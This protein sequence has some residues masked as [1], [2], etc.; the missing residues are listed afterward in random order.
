MKRKDKMKKN[1]MLS[2]G[3]MLVALFFV[4]VGISSRQMKV[5]LGLG[6][7]L[8]EGTFIVFENKEKILT[9]KNKNILLILWMTFL[10]TF[11]YA[12]SFFNPKNDIFKN[13]Q[14][15]S[16]SLVQDMIVARN[17]GIK[18]TGPYGLGEYNRENRTISNYKSQYGLQ[19]KFFQ[20]FHKIPGNNTFCAICTA[21][22]FVFLCFLIKK[23]FN[24]LLAF[25]FFITFLLSPWIVNFARNLYWVEFT[26]FI[27][28]LLGLI[29]S[30]K[31]QN[32]KIRLL[33]YVGAFLSILVKSLCG[34]EY[35]TVIML[36]LVAFPLVDFFI[37]LLNK[38]RKGATRL[39]KA[40]ILL[41]ICAILGFALALLIHAR[42]RGNGDI[43]EGLKSIYKHDVLRRTL[44]GNPED[45]PAVYAGSL[46]ASIKDVLRRYYNF[47]FCFHTDII[48]GINGRYFLLLTLIPLAIF[49]YKALH[50][51]L[52]VQNIALYFV[53][54]ISSVSWFVLGKSHSYI[55]VHMNYVLW[56]FGFV[57]ICFYVI[58]EEVIGFFKSRAIP[59][60]RSVLK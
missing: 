18:D 14:D 8:T 33:C 27:P 17:D 45:F 29:C 38:D 2:F 28:M 54:Y 40:V 20:I 56:Y 3:L 48:L 6:I 50:K 23:K 44:G 51:R 36:G 25:C 22:T 46:N 13:F 5:L 1:V 60:I 41:G 49:M 39:L 24:T 10:M 58:L 55:H 21:L 53:F 30:I 9:K 15:D 26:W 34:Y 43:I 19:G 35:L 37:A 16:E 57:Q 4:Y 47:H 42:I 11:N 12:S 52:D 31:I 32:K 7:L 59:Y